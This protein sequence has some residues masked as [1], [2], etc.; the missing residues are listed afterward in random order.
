M[1]NF[2]LAVAAVFGVVALAA[3]GG[4]KAQGPS[5]VSANA[6]ESNAVAASDKPI[7]FPFKEFQSV[8]TDAK[9][10]EYV[11]VPSYEWIQEAAEK[12]VEDTTFIWYSQSMEK[13]GKDYSEVYFLGDVKTVPNAYIIAIPKGQEAKVGDQVVTWWQSGS[14]MQRAIVVDDKNP[15][16]PVVRYLDLDYDNP[17]KSRDGK[18]TIG[19][20]DEQLKPNSFFVAKEMDPGT[21]VV[22]GPDSRVARLIRQGP[23][24]ALV[25]GWAGRMQMHPISAVKPIPFK[26]SFSP[27][28]KVQALSIGT[29]RPGTVSKVDA[30][31]GRVFVKFDFPA[32]EKAIAFG[33]VQKQ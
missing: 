19:Q 10:D 20:M 3:C 16:E 24:H 13:P 14:G 7:V 18:T 25:E 33:N 2:I 30:R 22:I 27:G 28:D 8:P 29:L 15:A 17:A 26:D 9:A 1:K 31:N 4:E 11:L 32:E 12:G 23:T 21:A 6:G 5:N